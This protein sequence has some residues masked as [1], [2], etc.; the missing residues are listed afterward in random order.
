MR[1]DVLPS[2]DVLTK[3]YKTVIEFAKYAS[4]SVDSSIIRKRYMKHV[5]HKTDDWSRHWARDRWFM[6]DGLPRFL[7]DDVNSEPVNPDSALMAAIELWEEMKLDADRAMD[8]II[9]YEISYE[10]TKKLPEWLRNENAFEYIE[11]LHNSRMEH[12]AKLRLE[13][14]NRRA[15]LKKDQAK[16]KWTKYSWTAGTR[17]VT[18]VN[19]LNPKDITVVDTRGIPPHMLI[20]MQR[21][22]QL[23]GLEIQERWT[24]FRSGS[25]YTNK[26]DIQDDIDNTP[27]L[28]FHPVNIKRGKNY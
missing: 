10:A 26:K 13:E 9:S 14:E 1:F 17:V 19:G 22:K 4:T 25:A 2:S 21:D 28:K 12:A 23:K 7:R 27:P 6:F 16:N 18:T 8:R 5:P 11:M 15:Q 24:K 3:D 20:Q